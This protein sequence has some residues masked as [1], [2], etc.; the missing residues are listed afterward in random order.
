[1]NKF[2]WILFLSLPWNVL[3]ET[4]SARR[5]IGEDYTESAERYFRTKSSDHSAYGF[6]KHWQELDFTN[7]PEIESEED[8][9]RQ[10]E[11]IRDLRFLNDP[12]KPDFKRRLPWLF[13]DDGCYM[14]AHYTSELLKKHFD[15]NSA[16]IYLFGNLKVST[17]NTASGFVS[18]W[19]HTAAV[20]RVGEKVFVLDPALEPQKPLTLKAW[21]ELQGIEKEQALL[22]VCDAQSYMATSSC[23]GS[24]VDQYLAKAHSQ[25]FLHSERSR[26]KALHRNPED[27]L[28]DNPPWKKAPNAF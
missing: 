19:F 16:R 28:G 24:V 3:A 25:M 5:E 14:R 4:I 13:P 6:R 12:Q 2:L 17:T 26:Q 7:I 21:V 9:F 22:S 15:Q 11:S 10:F 27:V 1:M 23:Q 18:W 20:V 8:V